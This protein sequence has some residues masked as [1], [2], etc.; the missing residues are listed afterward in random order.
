MSSEDWNLLTQIAMSVICGI[1]GA[2]CRN[3]LDVIR[4]GNHPQFHGLSA[5]DKR[6]LI[7][8]NPFRYKHY[9]VGAVAAFVGVVTLASDLSTAH[10]AVIALIS[11]LS[12]NSFLVQRMEGGSEGAGDYY[13]Y[14]A[15]A[16]TNQWEAI[17][18]KYHHLDG[19]AQPAATQENLNV[20]PLENDGSTG[21]L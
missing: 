2:E 6:R 8:E 21:A 5:E 4:I 9:L 1:I 17:A 12:G 7:K 20:I 16:V 15:G 10:Q 18:K 13:G 14:L 11:S 3:A 19:A